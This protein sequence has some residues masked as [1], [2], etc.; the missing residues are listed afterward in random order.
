MRRRSANHIISFLHLDRV[1]LSIF[2]PSID[3]RH[4]IYHKPSTYQHLSALKL[5]NCALGAGCFALLPDAGGEEKSSKSI[6]AHRPLFALLPL[7]VVRWFFFCPEDRMGSSAG[8]V[9]Q[10][11]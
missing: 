7:V 3:Y 4:M 11:L 5:L 10:N 1:R 9:G 8:G 2:S 6:S